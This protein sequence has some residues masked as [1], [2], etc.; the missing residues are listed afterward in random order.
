MVRRKKLQESCREKKK[1][2]EKKKKSSF[3]SN[4][5]SPKGANFQ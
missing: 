1:F 5:Q 4:L 3:A 2:K